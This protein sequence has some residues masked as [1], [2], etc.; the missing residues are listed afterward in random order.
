MLRA[1]KLKRRPGTG[2]HSNPGPSTSRQLQRRASA[3]S[4]CLPR[5]RAVQH[6]VGGGSGGRAELSCLLLSALRDCCLGMSGLRLRP[7]L[8]RGGVLEQV[9]ARVGTSCGRSVSE[10]APRSAS[11]CRASAALASETT[12]ATSRAHVKNSDASHL[13][14]GGGGV[15]RVGR[16]AD[17]E[18]GER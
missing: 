2:Y 1:E 7:S 6:G 13:F 15:H 9:T 12:T 10:D 16:T 8:L 18:A 5:P 17:R 4:I 14:N 3:G 11:T